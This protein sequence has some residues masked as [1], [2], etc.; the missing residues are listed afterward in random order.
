MA[1]TGRIVNGPAFQL[2]QQ[3]LARFT[4]AERRNSCWA[5]NALRFRKADSSRGAPDLH[6]VKVLVALCRV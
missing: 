2:H 1:S 3:Q 5:S 6:N 4:E